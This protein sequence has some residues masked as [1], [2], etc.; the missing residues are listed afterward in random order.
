MADEHP[1][2]LLD[3][4]QMARVMNISPSTLDSLVN[5][6]LPVVLLGP[7]TPRFDPELARDWWRKERV[8]RKGK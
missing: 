7:R 4:E 5:D 3:R 8:V 6:G 1:P 2:M